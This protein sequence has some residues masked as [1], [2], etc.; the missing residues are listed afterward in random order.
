MKID[1][2]VEGKFIY[3]AAIARHRV[4]LALLTPVTVI[5]PIKNNDGSL[6]IVTSGELIAEG[7][8]EFWLGWDRRLL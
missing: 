6:S 3:G 4:P 5:L 2:L 1:G 8:R 7:Y